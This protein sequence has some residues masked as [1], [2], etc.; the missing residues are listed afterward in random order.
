MCQAHAQLA[1]VQFWLVFGGQQFFGGKKIRPQFFG[2]NSVTI[3][4]LKNDNRIANFI[5]GFSGIFAGLS[6]ATLKSPF[7][8]QLGTSPF[9]NDSIR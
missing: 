5:A 6:W 7:P 2:P 8:L 3:C 9:F 1:H 4:D